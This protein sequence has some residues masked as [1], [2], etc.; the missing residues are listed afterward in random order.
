MRS[1]L[2]GTQNRLGEVIDVFPCI[3][4]ILLQSIHIVW[5]CSTE[6][7]L[8]SFARNWYVSWFRWLSHVLWHL[9][10]GHI[11]WAFISSWRPLFIDCLLLK[12]CNI[13]RIIFMLVHK[14]VMC[15]TKEPYAGWKKPRVKTVVLVNIGHIFL[16]FDY[17]FAKLFKKMY[18]RNLA[19]ST[20]E[21]S[22]LIIWTTRPKQKGFFWQC[23]VCIARL[24]GNSI[25][26]SHVLS[27]AIYLVW[28]S[29]WLD[30][31]IVLVQLTGGH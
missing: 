21:I 9:N 14:R 23:L 7:I 17:F 30:L 13:R 16:N 2:L 26:H 19:T 31:W 5:D 27:K 6:S 15:Y 22:S 3:F 1:P 10:K 11:I 8:L 20:I 12:M 18:F 24:I 4:F 28:T 29:I 25:I